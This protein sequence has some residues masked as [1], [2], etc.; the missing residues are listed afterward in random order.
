MDFKELDFEI[1]IVLDYLRGLLDDGAGPGTLQIFSHIA[2]TSD[3]IELIIERIEKELRLI[4]DLT[5]KFLDQIIPSGMEPKTDD[6]EKL[7]RMFEL[8]RLDSKSFFIF[9]RIFCDTMCRLIRLTY[10]DNGRQLPTSM[11]DLLKSKKAF[12]SDKDFFSGLKEIMSWF[13]ELREKR[14][15]IEHY[16]GGLRS[17]TTRNGLMGFDIKG[18][19]NIDKSWGTDTVQPFSTY[20]E[21]TIKSITTSLR[22]ISEKRLV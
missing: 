1:G 21:D 11:K 20:I 16:L 18:L 2:D 15:E 8:L 14:V 12:E 7:V 9:V 17:T 6:V 5:S 13:L 10:G 22:Y 19:R 3:E 4:N